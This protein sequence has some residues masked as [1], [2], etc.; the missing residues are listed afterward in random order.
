[1]AGAQNT[2]PSLQIASVVG[3]SKADWKLQSGGRSNKSWVVSETGAAP[4]VVK[5]FNPERGNALFGNDAYCE[6]KALRHLAGTGLA[7][8]LIR[9]EEIEGRPVLVY[10][11]VKRCQTPERAESA[12][13]TLR[14]LHMLDAPSDLQSK[15]SDPELIL[16]MGEAFARVVPD[17]PSPPGLPKLQKT[18][19]T[20]LHG[21]PV[22]ANMIA[23]ETGIVLIDWQ[24]P[25]L[26]DPVLDLFTY[27]SPAMQQLYR[28]TPLTP[29]EEHRFL[30]AYED[31]ETI[32]RLHLLAPI[33]HWRMAAYC[34]F[35]AANGE[36]D[37]EPCVALELAAM[38]QR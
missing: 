38:A 31:A 7:P 12:A 24:C 33:L 15:T 16:K 23:T 5:V 8:R 30:S 4:V 11:Y 20:F 2:K 14:R 25:G 13:E 18:P 32:D 26:G 10:S 17:F 21:D 35:M 19:L 27:L 22:S 36:K 1:M 6:A 34:S 28:D 29:T 9:F 3:L 37:Y